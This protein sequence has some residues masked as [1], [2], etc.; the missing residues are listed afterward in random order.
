MTKQYQFI[1]FSNQACSNLLKKEATISKAILEITRDN[2]EDIFANK[3][4]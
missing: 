3:T 2:L 1:S 4:W